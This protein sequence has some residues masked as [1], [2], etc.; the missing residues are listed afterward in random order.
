MNKETRKM[1]HGSIRSI[2]LNSLMKEGTAALTE[3]FLIHVA[4]L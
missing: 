4:H 1:L 2:A 3:E